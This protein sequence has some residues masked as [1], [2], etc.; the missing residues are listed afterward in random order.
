MRRLT[1]NICTGLAFATLLL[2]ATR[3]ANAQ[4]PP[5]PMILLTPQTIVASFI[6]TESELREALKQHTFKRDVVL[7]TIGPNGEVTGQYI[8]NS[9]FLFDDKGNR[10]ERVTYHPP[11]TIREMR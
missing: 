5:P 3:M 4:E 10:I 6:K 8:R 11:S 1:K 7:Q 2:T 9:Q